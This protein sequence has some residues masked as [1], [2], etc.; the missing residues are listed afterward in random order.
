[1]SCHSVSEW[2]WVMMT[3]WVKTGG[4]RNEGNRTLLHQTGITVLKVQL[5]QKIHSQ[6]VIHTLYSLATVHRGE[7]G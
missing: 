2:W 4:L 6:L 1:M 5:Q 7:T 3:Y